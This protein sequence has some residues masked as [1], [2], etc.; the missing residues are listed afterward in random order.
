MSSIRFK[1]NSLIGS[2]LVNDFT[3]KL[4]KLLFKTINRNGITIDLMDST[5]KP[6]IAAS[7]FFNT[8]ESAEIRFIKKYISAGLPVLEL[9]SSL[10]VVGCIAAKNNLNK[11]VGIEAN[12]NLKNYCSQLIANNRI[13]NYSVYNYALFKEKGIVPFNI[14]ENNTIGKIGGDG[15][16]SVVNL[17]ALTFNEILDLYSFNDEYLLI[18]DIEGAEAFFIFFNSDLS[19]CRLIIIELHDF[20]YDGIFYSIAEMISG[21]ETKGFSLSEQHGNCFVFVK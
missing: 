20:E 18:S 1:I 11:V 7:I 15:N 16:N 6:R 4:I 17:K 5:V 19:H 3:G 2:L 10:G 21:I 14:G 13:S 9:G 8:Y 12:Q